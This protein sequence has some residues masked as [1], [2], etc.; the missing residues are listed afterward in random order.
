MQGSY[1]RDVR[2]SQAAEWRLTWGRQGWC[3][4][5]AE[6]VPNKLSRGHVDDDVVRYTLRRT[7]DARDPPGLPE[8]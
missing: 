4:I 8:L 1:V 5:N 3:V 2:Q 7:P 6:P